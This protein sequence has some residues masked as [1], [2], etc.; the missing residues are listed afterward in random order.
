MKV[1][2]SLGH[3]TFYVYSAFYKYICVYYMCVSPDHMLLHTCDTF[4]VMQT[5]TQQGDHNFI[6]LMHGLQI[7]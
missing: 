7:T 5:S 3:N 4:R 6:H 1:Q 2:Y